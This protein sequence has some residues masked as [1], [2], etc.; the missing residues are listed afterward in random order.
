MKTELVDLSGKE[1]Q[2][3]MFLGDWKRGWGR[4]NTKTNMFVMGCGINHEYSPAVHAPCSICHHLLPPSA[5]FSL[6]T[7]NTALPLACLLLSTLIMNR[8]ENTFYQRHVTC[9]IDWNYAFLRQLFIIIPAVN[10]CSRFPLAQLRSE[11]LPPNVSLLKINQWLQFVI[12]CIFTGV[13]HIDS[14]SLHCPL[15]WQPYNEGKQ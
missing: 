7:S 12:I 4:V 2:T 11:S 13:A 15:C 8:W 14:Q 5:P 9:F 3:T 10:H 6:G 1:S